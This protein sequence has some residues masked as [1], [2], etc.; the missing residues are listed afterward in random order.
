[1]LQQLHH[2]TDGSIKL[3]A[4]METSHL[5]NYLR[6]TL[7]RLWTVVLESQEKKNSYTNN[8]YGKRVLTQEEA[9]A[10]ANKTLQHLA[11]YT[12][13]AFFRG[14]EIAGYAE[15]STLGECYNEI[16]DL[17]GS[18]MGRTTALPQTSN[19]LSAEIITEAEQYEAGDFD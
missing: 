19:L 7:R 13:E 14:R 3:I 10:M 6:F 18:I 16:I 15:D 11:P 4:E 2:S 17:L 5:L 8:L 1:M 9:A 12:F